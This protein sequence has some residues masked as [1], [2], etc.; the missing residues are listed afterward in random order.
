MVSPSTLKLVGAEGHRY[1]I[2]T[3]K[4]QLKKFEQHL[5]EKDWQEVHEG[6][7]VKLCPSPEGGEEIFILCRSKAR[8]E[9]EEAMHNRFTE[10]IKE[11]LERI[12]KSCQSG[13]VKK[14]NVI[15]RRI[16]RLLQKNQRASSLFEITVKEEEGKVK[17][18]WTIDT[19]N[20]DW[21]RLVLPIKNKHQRLDTTGVMEGLY[22]TDR[23]R[24]GIPYSE[25]RF[26]VAPYLASKRKPSQGSYFRMLHS[27]CVMEKL[28]SNM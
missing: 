5:V 25:A 24:R 8:K 14:V 7:E 9:K 2:G 1:I 23:S 6:L 26:T 17:V 28:C 12:K 27:V 13:R 19:S 22:P 20:A 10:Q 21:A 11:G 3:P 15:E 18:D 4:N 16:G